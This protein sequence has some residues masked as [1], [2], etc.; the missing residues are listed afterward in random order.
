MI[1][2]I[3]HNQIRLTARFRAKDAPQKRKN[4]VEDSAPEQQRAQEMRAA[5]ETKHVLLF[6]LNYKACILIPPNC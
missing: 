1:Q 5:L 4:D 3:K 2:I 6:T